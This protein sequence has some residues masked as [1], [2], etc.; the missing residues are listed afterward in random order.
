MGYPTAELAKREYEKSAAMM[1]AGTPHDVAPSMNTEKIDSLFHTL[2]AA[3]SLSEEVNKLVTLLAGHFP[4]RPESPN[5]S[6]VAESWIDRVEDRS[7][8]V[9]E[10]VSEAR[11]RLQFLAS[12]FQL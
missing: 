4:P 1:N 12:H 5:V 2:D 9:Y 8:Y 3:Q 10:R 6:K 11:E 7:R